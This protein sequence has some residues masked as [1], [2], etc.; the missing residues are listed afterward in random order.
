M[1]RLEWG[2]VRVVAEHP[3]LVVAGDW[4]EAV[5]AEGVGVVHC[6]VKKMPLAEVGVVVPAKGLQS[7]KSLCVAVQGLGVL[8]QFVPMLQTGRT[9]LES[10]TA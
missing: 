7:R 6:F 2:R 3:L 1:L 8:E 10:R 9:N 4:E 5:A